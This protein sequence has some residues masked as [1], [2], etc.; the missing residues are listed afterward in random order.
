MPSD[1]CPDS[2]PAQLEAAYQTFEHGAMLWRKTRGYIVLPFNPKTGVQTG[3]VS[4]Y[5]DSVTVYRDTSGGVLPPAGLL[6]PV[7]G[8]GLVWRGD[9]FEEPGFGFQAT[10]GWAT[11][12]ETGYTISEQTGSRSVMFNGGTSQALFS[13]FT[14]PDGRILRL[15]RLANPNQMWSI[16]FVSP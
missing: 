2:P 9:I 13:I 11:E 6:A 12:D 1:S 10:L 15:S 5:P 16:N 8:F 3:I 4:L 14:L 7:S